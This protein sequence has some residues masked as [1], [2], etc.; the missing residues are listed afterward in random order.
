VVHVTAKREAIENKV[1]DQLLV[2]NGIAVEAESPA[3]PAQPLVDRYRSLAASS[4]MTEEATAQPADVQSDFDVV[5]V[6]APPTKIISFMADLNRDDTNYLGV[7][8]DD[9]APDDKVP[10][11]QGGPTKKISLGLEKYNRGVV[12]QQQKDYFARNKAMY[13]QQSPEGAYLGAGRGGA[14]DTAKPIEQEENLRQRLARDNYVNQGRAQRV[15][16]P[17]TEDRQGGG[18]LHK[19]GRQLKASSGAERE[20]LQVLFVLAPSEEPA[21]SPPA[22]NRAE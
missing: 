1:F 14:L 21:A 2:S 15:Q 20:N 4:R 3:E 12:S 18:E 22:E 5:L 17:K 16:V 8:V 11:L 6:E 7:S 19:L 13:Y 9:S 10:A